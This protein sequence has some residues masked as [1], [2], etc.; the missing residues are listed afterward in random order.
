MENYK[1]ISGLNYFR[2]KIKNFVSNTIWIPPLSFR[3][4]TV[5]YKKDY[6]KTN[7][8][9][10]EEKVDNREVFD[11]SNITF[12]YLIDLK[13]EV[14]T[15][16]DK[17]DFNKFIEFKKKYR[18]KKY[19]KD[20]ILEKANDIK[21]DCPNLIEN[22]TKFLYDNGIILILKEIED[23]AFKYLDGFAC[24]L[25]KQPI[26]V[27][28]KPIYKKDYKRMLFTIAHEIFHL[29]YTEPEDEKMADIFAGGMLLTDRDIL[30]IIN[31][32]NI[33]Y[34]NINKNKAIELLNKNEDLQKELF[35]EIYKENG[36]S[37]KAIIKTLINYGYFTG[38]ESKFDCL[39]DDMKKK[40]EKNELTANNFN[41]LSTKEMLEI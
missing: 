9:D 29:F 2:D 5:A 28:Y 32:V 39:I 6:K 22:I 25:D 36:I 23:D 34:S 15:L 37:M 30:R 35:E 7:N 20:C 8:I 18:A 3:V 4:N 40:L 41:I 31:N 16:I 13:N 12:E 17:V 14:K 26:I 24:F 1:S 10:Y 11:N 19:S 21:N 38:A 33:E 27:I